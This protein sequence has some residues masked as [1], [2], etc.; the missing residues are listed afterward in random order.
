MAATPE[1]NSVCAAAKT[2]PEKTPDFYFI[3]ECSPGHVK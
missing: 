3:I 2:N 1:D